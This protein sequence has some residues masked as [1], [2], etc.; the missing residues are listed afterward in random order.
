[1]TIAQWFNICNTAN[2]EQI[3]T[4]VRESLKYM[5]KSYDNNFRPWS[6]SEFAKCDQFMDDIAQCY[7]A[8]E[9]KV[10]MRIYGI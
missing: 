4:P 6:E 3:L 8:L 5:L 10:T 2:T 7:G 9:N 1:M